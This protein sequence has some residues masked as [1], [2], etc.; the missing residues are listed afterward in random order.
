MRAAGEAK[1]P[2]E[3]TQDAIEKAALAQLRAQW[4]RP[5]GLLATRMVDMG[6]Q[7]SL[8]SDLSIQAWK[9][10]QQVVVTKNLEE[11]VVRND[12]PLVEVD[13][14]VVWALRRAVKGA[15]QGDLRGERA[16]GEGGVGEEV[17]P[18][19]EEKRRRRSGTTSS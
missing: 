10:V 7:T 5:P 4:S 13:P 2:A 3:A 11:D 12:K 19:G 15:T 6:V 17:D 14:A 16:K 18:E 8:V 9:P 1:Q